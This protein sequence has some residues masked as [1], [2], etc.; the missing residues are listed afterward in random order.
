MRAA[1][2]CWTIGPELSCPTSTGKRSRKLMRRIHSS[3]L[4]PLAMPTATA[5]IP[6]ADIVLF[7]T[8]VS[9]P[10]TAEDRDIAALL[11]ERA[12]DRVILVLNKMD[13]LPAEKVKLHTEAYWEMVP[14]R[15]DWMMTTAT[16][17]DNLAKLLDMI[18]RSLPRGP[19]YY[20]GDQITAS[21]ITI[22]FS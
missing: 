3:R 12:P 14:L 21:C 9:V 4:H 11:G 17:G 19:E 7:V 8:D 16:T 2:L 22:E 18:L 6:D 15:R 5:A 20:P 13:L 10:P 1:D